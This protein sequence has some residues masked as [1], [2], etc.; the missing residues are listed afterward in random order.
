MHKRL[1]YA[2]FRPSQNLYLVTIWLLLR[3][4]ANYFAA[5]VPFFDVKKKNSSLFSEEF[6]V[7][8]TRLERQK[9]SIL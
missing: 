4:G 8:D 9:S 2:K 3:H 1:F 5:K 7:D 6:M